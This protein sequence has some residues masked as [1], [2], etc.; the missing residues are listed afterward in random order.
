VIAVILIIAAAVA[1]VVYR[2]RRDPQ[3][4]TK[5]TE[6]VKRLIAREKK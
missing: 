4:I 6:R 3:F 2:Q 1:Y 5:L